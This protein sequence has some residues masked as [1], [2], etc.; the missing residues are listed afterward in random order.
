MIGNVYDK[1]QRHLRKQ[2]FIWVNSTTRLFHNISSDPLQK[3]Q[4]KQQNKINPIPLL[5]ISSITLLLL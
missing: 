4:S 2:Q 1:A 3:P 5:T